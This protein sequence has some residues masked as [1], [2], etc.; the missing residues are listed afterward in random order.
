MINL[1]CKRCQKTFKT[2]WDFNKHKQRK[3]KCMTKEK[4]LTCKYCNKMFTRGSSVKVHLLICKM[5]GKPNI[6][7]IKII[8]FNTEYNQNAIES[9]VLTNNVIEKKLCKYWGAI[10]ALIE[11]INFNPKFPQYHNIYLSNL[12]HNYCYVFEKGKWTI[13]IVNEKID[14]L[15]MMVLFRLVNYCADPITQINSEN[16]KIYLDIFK[17]YSRFT[18]IDVI[19]KEDLIDI[20]RKIYPN[21]SEPPRT[22]KEYYEECGITISGDKNDKEIKKKIRRN[23]K[24]LFKEEKH[25]IKKIYLKVKHLLYANQKMIKETRMMY[26]KQKLINKHNSG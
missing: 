11:Y 17:A 21:I 25:Q 3:T 5:K 12:S 26:E 10:P 15:I 14:S 24:I 6:K 4:R 20:N 7:N 13:G 22:I 9:V 19:N 18:S 1:I 8:N 16:T 2:K 23:E